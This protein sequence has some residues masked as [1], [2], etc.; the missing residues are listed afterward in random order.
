MNGANN[1]RQFIRF[2]ATGGIAAAINFGSRILYS[3]I[4]S[5]RVA[6]VLAYLNGM[7]IAYFLARWFVFAKSG[8]TKRRE[9]LDFILVNLFSALQVWLISVGLAEYLFPAVAFTF[10]SESVAHFFGLTVPAVTSYLG[11]MRLTFR[12]VPADQ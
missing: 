10:H 11:H 5:Y 9:F 12:Q 1:Y 7:V 2:L 8:R 3:Q 6:V 4:Y